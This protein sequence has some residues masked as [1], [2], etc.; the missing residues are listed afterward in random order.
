MHG[1]TSRRYYHPHLPR[2]SPHGIGK[3]TLSLHTLLDQDVIDESLAL[4]PSGI[5]KPAFDE[6]IRSA[7]QAERSDGGERRGKQSTTVWARKQEVIDGVNDLI[8]E[9]KDIDSSIANQVPDL[10]N[11]VF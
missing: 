6:S 5:A 2:R 9:L 3:R 10:K 1:Y 7:P 4:N 8:E 11:G